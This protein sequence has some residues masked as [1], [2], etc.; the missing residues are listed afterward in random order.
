MKLIVN[1]GMVVADRFKILRFIAEG[2]MGEV[3][4]ARDEILGE[5]VALKFLSHR[6]LGDENVTRRF[7]REIQ[8]ARKVTHPNVCRVFDVY[9]HHVPIPG[10]RQ[11]LPVAFVTMELLQGV[12][13]EERISS[14]GPLSQDEALPVIVQLCRALNA[15]HGAGVIHRDFKSNNVILVPS[16]EGPERVVVTDFGLARSMTPTDPSC[17]PLT[18]DSLILGTADYMSPEQIRGEPVSSRSDLYSLGVV[19][20]EMLTG[21]KPYRASNPMQLLVKR[22]SEPPARPTDF[23]PGIDAHWEALIMRCLAEEPDER[24]GSIRDVLSALNVHGV[25]DPAEPVASRPA[26]EAVSAEPADAPGRSRAGWIAVFLVAALALLTWWASRGPGPAEESPTRSFNPKRLSSADGLEMDPALSPDGRR[27]AYSGE[28][29]PGVFRLFVRDV[30]DDAPARVLDTPSTHALEPVWTVDGESLV[31]HSLPDGGLWQAP[32]SRPSQARRLVAEGSNPSF[33]R[34][35]RWLAY[36][37]QGSPLFS[38]TT[39]P[40][41]SPSVIEV[42]DTQTRERRALTEA[43]RPAGGHGSPLFSADDRFVIFAASRRSRSELWAVERSTGRLIPILKSPAAYDPMLS[44][45]G[46]SLYFTARRREV[47]S[48]WRLSIDADSMAATSEAREVAGVGLSSIRRPRLSANGDLVF[49]AYLTGSNLWALELNE[50]GTV[51]GSPRPLTRGNDRYNRP[52]FSRD[53]AR[54]A[55]DHWKLGVDIDVFEMSADGGRPQRLT[56]GGNTN[57]HAGW[58]EDGRLIYSR[59]DVKG[60][61]TVRRLDPATEQ[62]EALL[63]LEPGDDW[64]RASPDGTMLAFHSPRAGENL[65]VW[66]RDLAVGPSW[67]LTFHAEPAGFPCW[68]NAGDAVAY[69]VKAQNGSSLWLAPLDGSDPRVLVADEGESWPYSFSPD[70]QK[71]LFAGRR[72]GRWNIHWVSRDGVRLRRLTENLDLTGYLRYPVWSPDGRTVVYERSQT[73]GDLFRVEGFE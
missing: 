70:D 12:T 23:V 29:E 30:T 61:A 16:E 7:R 5:K 49:A 68:S 53:G 15:A 57:S 69:H 65:D 32:L 54:L 34:D 1:T 71:I 42:F 66:I 52:S 59:I 63:T 36:Q 10:S 18:A 2:G 64:A 11:L 38:D 9:Q 67:R 44:L 21:E 4:E 20:F 60:R 47:K 35:G 37:S 45:D 28:D 72:D 33:S 27:L 46:R 48:L 14:G 22:V 40:A 24:P 17:T 73:T 41:S 55:F 6:N 31:Y 50:E 26:A 3:Y 51:L 62:D 8:L 25:L 19:I 56:R 58:T 13:L 39:T 43:G